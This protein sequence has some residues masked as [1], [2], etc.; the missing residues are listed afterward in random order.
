MIT[1]TQELRFFYPKSTEKKQFA[2]LMGH[3]S[4]DMTR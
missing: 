3:Y 2:K 1:I 4:P